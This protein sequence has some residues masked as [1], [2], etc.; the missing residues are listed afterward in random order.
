MSETLMA[1]GDYRFSI[2]TA[3]YH[4][5]KRQQ[6]Y[7]WHS[8]ARLQ[9][10]P[11]QQFVGEGE[12]CLTLEGVI[13]PHYQ[14]GYKQIERM[15]EQA[16]KGKPLLLVDGLGFVWG[17]WVIIRLEEEQSYLLPN[18]MPRKQT[19]SLELVEYGRD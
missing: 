9:R 2:D 5:V 19:F 6:S 15:R 12:H 8:Q 3:A 16:T 1:L 4:L 7:R 17:Q 14:G 13:Y 11:A 10:S 18:G